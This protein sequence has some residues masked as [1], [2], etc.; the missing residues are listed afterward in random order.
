[1]TWNI[2]HDGIWNLSAPWSAR[3]HLVARIIRD[4]RPDVACLQEASLRQ[5][6][7]LEHDL[8]EYE[9]LAGPVSGATVL[10]GWTAKAAPLAKAIFRDFYEAGEMCPILLRRERATPI[11]VGSFIL[12]DAPTPRAVNWARIRTADGADCF[13]SS[14]HLGLAPWYAL[15]NARALVHALDRMWN[16]LPQILAGDFN[17]LPQW[18]VVRSIVA[19]GQSRVPPFHDAWTEAS[20][21]AGRGRTYHWGFG[22]PGPRLDYVFVRPRGLVKSAGVAPEDVTRPFPSDHMPVLVELEFPE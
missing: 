19:R 10:R 15:R 6:G 16:G 2:L 11:E 3:R 17:A 1:M 18:P 21:R 13:V 20:A 8:P 9:I 4:A 22:L 7:D 12:D 5:A 14:T